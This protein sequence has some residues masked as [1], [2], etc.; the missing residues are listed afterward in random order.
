MKKLLIIAFMI[1]LIITSFE[2]GHV[3]AYYKNQLMEDY[4]ALLGV[5]SIKVN[6]NII[7]GPS[8]SQ[9]ELTNEYFHFVNSNLYIDNKVAPGREMY[10]DLLIDPS[11]TDVSVRYDININL[12]SNGS[13]E[14]QKVENFVQTKD[15]KEIISSTIIETGN[16][17]FTGVLPFEKIEK[18]YVSK[19]RVY[20]VWKNY[21]IKNA[22]DTLKGETEN[23]KLTLPIKIKFEQYMGEAINPYKK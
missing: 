1:M 13:L 21:E 8:L 14:V 16:N 20:L 17:I 4:I 5:W 19:V 23:S 15:S 18:G 7:E 6:N 9:I 2:I 3:Y 10:V 11:D 12:E 22:E